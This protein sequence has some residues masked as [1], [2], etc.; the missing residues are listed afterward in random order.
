MVPQRV[1]AID[2]QAC[3]G[4]APNGTQV[5][6]WERAQ[7]PCARV[8]KACL[9]ASF[10]HNFRATAGARQECC[11][12]LSMLLSAEVLSRPI[13][14]HTSRSQTTRGLFRELNPGPLAPEARIIPL[15]QTAGAYPHFFQKFR[16]L[17]KQ[18][19]QARRGQQ[20][21]PIAEAG[22]TGDSSGPGQRSPDE[23]QAISR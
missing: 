10:S 13:A 6:A 20:K 14:S 21:A 18:R 15:D 4:A 9:L 19:F 5:S 3:N 22:R 7:C 17:K 11:L 23:Q 1:A 16:G 12:S 2:N 8:L